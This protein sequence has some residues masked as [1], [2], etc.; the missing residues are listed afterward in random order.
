MTNDE[1]INYGLNHD[2]ERV[3]DLADAFEQYRIIV[4]R[5]I[6]SEFPIKIALNSMH[7]KFGRTETSG[8]RRPMYDVF[9]PRKKVTL[10]ELT[11]LYPPK[12]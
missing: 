7:G 4:S 2:D 11:T 10:R 12:R 6:G 1:L 8:E 5:F 9:V 3:N